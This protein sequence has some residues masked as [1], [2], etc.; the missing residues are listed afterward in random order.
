MIRK[1]K[2][3]FPLEFVDTVYVYPS[4]TFY[5]V[6][7]QIA[8]L[9]LLGLDLILE[10]A[11]NVKCRYLNVKAVP[12]KNKELLSNYKAVLEKIEPSV[13]EYKYVEVEGKHHVHMNDPQLVAPH[14]VEFVEKKPCEN[15]G[16]N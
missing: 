3:L 12:E 15:G 9:G 11:S 5:H 4:L 16:E 8:G 6:F 7:F 14:I 13:K 2:E 1:V 10:F